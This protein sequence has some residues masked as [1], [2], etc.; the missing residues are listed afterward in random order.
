MTLGIQKLPA[1]RGE[2]NISNHTLWLEIRKIFIILLD[3]GQFNLSACGGLFV[4]STEKVSIFFW[5][6]LCGIVDNKLPSVTPFIVSSS[7]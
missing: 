2:E 7:V 3:S 6:F 1:K 5:L 4:R